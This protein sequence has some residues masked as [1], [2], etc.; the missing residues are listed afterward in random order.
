MS[1]RVAA[2]DLGGSSGRVMAATVGPGQLS[3][4]EVHRFG[5]GPMRLG[6]TLYWD[7][8]A[9]YQGT[10]TGIAAAGDVA[11]VG[12][13]SWGVDYGLLD[14]T[15]A[16]L[17]NPVHHRDSRTDGI[18]DLVRE[19]VP[20]QELYDVTG[21]QQL[22]FNT[23]YQ[24]VSERD[25]ERFRV[26]ERLLLVPDLLAYWLTGSVG[27][28]RT[29]AS[30]TQLYDVRAGTWAADIAK[31][32]DIPP[33]LLP[34]L[35]DTGDIIGPIRP[36]IAAES[37]LPECPVV[38]VGSHD[39]ASALVGTPAEP[40]ANFA[41]ISSGTW[42]L[43]GV[44]L[45]RPVLTGDAM[46]ANFT[47]ETGVD[48]TIRFLRNVMGLWVLSET[49]RTWQANGT[50]VELADVLRDAAAE[51]GLRA[52]VDINAPEFLPPGD[53]T[54]RIAAVCRA[55]GQRPPDTPAA[56]VR[57]IL[58]SLALAYRRTLRQ[59][60]ELS[61]RPVDVVH[62]VGGGTRNELL[63]QLTADACGVPVLAGP[64][65]AAALGNALVQARALG[66][67]LPDLAAMRALVRATHDVR[68]YE[69]AESR[70]AWDD[71]EAC[72]REP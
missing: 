35:R 66:A 26:A 28:E 4:D 1:L 18:A 30:T 70:A 64:G 8:L 71:A 67:D 25:T 6:P 40:G 41:F 56:T 49:L 21:L 7:I 10:L 62:I 59:A 9:L 17:A 48:G 55:T 53:M 65:E 61:G 22:P 58:D 19:T 37:G 3:L 29:V 69:P 43:A 51:P 46:R 5:N 63:S 20:D 27:V 12:I 14:G 34:P 23:L 44:E 47:N 36:R 50:P 45:D 32:L 72:V 60:A 33:R 24:L 57:C 31:R 11:A 68:R 13:D 15:G 42:S 52:V 39:T 54:A 16:L 2:V 38:V